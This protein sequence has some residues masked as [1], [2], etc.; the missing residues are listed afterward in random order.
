MDLH[1]Q[2]ESIKTE[3]NEAIQNILSTTQFIG[4]PEKDRFESEYAAMMGTQFCIGVGNGTD[5]LFLALKAMGIG[6]GDEVIVPANSFIATSE[7]VSANGAKVVFCDVHEEDFLLNLN[8][9]EKLLSERSVKKGGRIKAVI[10]VHLYG[11]MV[12]MPRLMR[13]A[14][15]YD[16]FILEDSAQAHFAEIDGVKA[17]AYGDVGSFS[18]YPGKNLGAYGDAGAL[19]TKN[20]TLALKIRKLANHGRI[21]KYD[22]DLEGYNSRLDTLQA[23]ILRVKLKHLETWTDLRRQKARY[24]EELFQNVSRI[25]LP[26]I[27]KD[28]SHAFH[29]YVVRVKN[30]TQVQN[31]LETAGIQTGV[32]YPKA[33]PELAAYQYL[34]HKPEDFPVVHKLQSEILSLPLFPEITREEQTYVANALKRI[35]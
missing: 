30:R 29:L 20:E 3:V 5:S 25:I 8:H 13:M 9:V 15:E 35:I 18:F 10:P 11:R 16:V 14:K 23:A 2:Y 34:N 31:Q 22:H 17:G 24:Y 27:P 19:I 1:R 6:A 7:V 28:N 12:D 26:H 32:H 4:G 33:L 21:T